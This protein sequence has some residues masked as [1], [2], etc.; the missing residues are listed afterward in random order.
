MEKMALMVKTVRMALLVRMESPV[1]MQQNIKLRMYLLD[2]LQLQIQTCIH[3]VVIL[4]QDYLIIL[5]F[6]VIQ[7][8]ERRMKVKYECPIELL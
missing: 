6:G 2:F 7:F 3:R 1:K 5:L 8:L 4:I